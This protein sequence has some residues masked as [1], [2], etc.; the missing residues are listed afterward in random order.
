MTSLALARTASTY[1]QQASSTKK[2]G[3]N[4]STLT[5]SSVTSKT[6]LTLLA[7]GIPAEVL[8]PTTMITS[9]SLT[10]YSQAN[11]AQLFE[12]RR[13]VAPFTA[14]S[15]TWATKPA[16]DSSVV[17][18][19]TTGTVPK[20]GPIQ[21]TTNILTMLQAMQADASRNF[22]FELK[23]SG[24][25]KTYKLSNTGSYVAVLNVDYSL[26]PAPPSVLAP[27]QGQ[28]VSVPQ[29]TLRV[30]APVQTI[31]GIRVQVDAAHDGV[32][33]DF[34]YTLTST[35][36]EVNLAATPGA[37][38]L[39]AHGVTAWRA[40]LQG[41]SGA[42]SDW[43]DWADYSYEPFGTV[44]ITEP[45]PPPDDVV[46][47]P[48]PP[49]VWSVSGMT[50]QAYRLFFTDPS[51]PASAPP[52]YDSGVVTSTANTATPTTDVASQTGHTYRVF[53]RIWD[54][55]DRVVVGGATEFV[56][57]Q[58]DFTYVLTATVDPFTAFTVDDMD[59]YPFANLRMT[60]AT[61][62]DGIQIIRDG[63]SVGVFNAA[64]LHVSGDDYAFI[65]TTAAPR[66]SHTWSVRAIVNG[67]VSAANPTFT[68]ELEPAGIWLSQPEKD[69]FLPFIT[70]AAQA[71][72]VSEDGGTFQILNG[73]YAVRVFGTQH[74]WSGTIT[75]EILAT[76]LTDAA[77]TGSD[78]FDLFMTM[79]A[80]QGD[81]MILSLLDMAIKVVPFNMTIQPTPTI[82][83]NGD[84]VYLA[85]F[86]FIEAP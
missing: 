22:G 62:P 25:S 41:P 2:A 73:S 20:N 11:T 10:I 24:G 83:R 38:T 52:I 12:V 79:R 43:S 17:A 59:P 57:T 70:Q 19:V 63:V 28:V 58:R 6:V 34:D 35:V 47:D 21:F 49:I 48:T 80:D 61:P 37:P 77:L 7:F 39:A 44:T 9:A 65:D 84:Y 30:A 66:R 27:G 64:D 54:D 23:I 71:I 26:K 13:L 42:W 50:Q 55:K 86:E 16:A 33:P 81:A 75:G 29:P 72:G 18:S 1:V 51:L 82:G 40:Q 3:A 46:T 74:G 76:T 85:S 67:E 53:V 8:L 69:R 45:G 36:A 32:T 56:E 4:P 15:V 5:V 78:L 31:T 68:R 60:R 14:S